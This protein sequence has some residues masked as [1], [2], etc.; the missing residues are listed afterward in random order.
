[1]RAPRRDMT[2]PRAWWATFAGLQIPAL[3]YIACA[4]VLLTGWVF[5]LGPPGIWVFFVAGCLSPVAVIYMILMSLRY[6]R[7][8]R[9]VFGAAV[10]IL[11]VIAIVLAVGM[12]CLILLSLGF[13]DM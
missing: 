10:V 8:T 13:P 6:Q 1:M 9:P 4:V 3:F 12:G 7:M 11:N 5:S 2:R